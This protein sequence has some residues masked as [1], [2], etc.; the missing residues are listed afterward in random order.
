MT[1]LHQEA[2]VGELFG[3]LTQ[4]MGH[5]IRQEAQLAK[6]DVQIQISQLSRSMLSVAA[7]G[8]LLWLAALALTTMVIV[9]L[10]NEA[11]LDP[12]LASLA[13]GVVLA[14]LGYVL[15]RRGLNRI[16]HIDPTPRRALESLKDDVQWAKEQTP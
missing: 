3:R 16:K 6:I 4:D 13:V 12:W 7:G 15:L 11:H 9:L 10:I 8:L 2:S 14:I 5:L 1:D